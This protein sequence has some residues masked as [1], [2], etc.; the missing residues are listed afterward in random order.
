MRFFSGLFCYALFQSRKLCGTFFV[1]AID[2]CLQ[3]SDLGYLCED[4]IYRY[5]RRGLLDARPSDL[6]EHGIRKHPWKQD[7]Q[8]K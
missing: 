6:P 7:K 3:D 2:F 1:S 8:K 4:T 5:L